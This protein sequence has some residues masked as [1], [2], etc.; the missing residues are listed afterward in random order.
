M[1][2]HNTEEKNEPA[3]H[4]HKRKNKIVIEQ[5]HNTLTFDISYGTKESTIHRRCILRYAIR[6]H[7][8]IDREKLILT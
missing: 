5:K 4:Q 8:K 3:V 7:R 1:G 6:A 2:K